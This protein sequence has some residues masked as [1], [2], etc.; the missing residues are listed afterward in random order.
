M[1][2]NQIDL[3]FIDKKDVDDLF[4][5]LNR[6]AKFFEP[7]VKVIKINK[8]DF[9]ATRG[10]YPKIVMGYSWLIE[11]K[12]MFDEIRKLVISN[13]DNLED[14]EH[15]K[16]TL[17]TP[18]IISIL[19]HEVAHVLTMTEY[20]DEEQYKK[21]LHHFRRA[22]VFKSDKERTADY[23]KLPYEKLADNLADELYYRNYNNII[24]IL[25]GKDVEATT[26]IMIDNLQIVSDMKDK[27]IYNV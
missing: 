9:Y 26:Q 6:I 21:D 19:L 16:I 22:A 20:S 4:I 14:E 11:E 13:I 12:E 24:K 3:N 10:F 27:Y 2:D 7:T 23:R 17:N 8:S 25:L 1:K 18:Q 15:L 5:K